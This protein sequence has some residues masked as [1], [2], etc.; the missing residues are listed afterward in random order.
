MVLPV[1]MASTDLDPNL[2]LLKAGAL[3]PCRHHSDIYL[4]THDRYAEKAAYG[5]WTNML[6]R[7]T[8]GLRHRADFMDCLAS[9]LEAAP[10]TCFICEAAYEPGDEIY[11]APGP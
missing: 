9:T 8:A 4:R 3:R 11:D 6:K 7:S 2:A 10:D 1:V 5:I